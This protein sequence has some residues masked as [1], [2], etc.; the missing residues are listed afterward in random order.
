ML[1]S[2]V[3]FESMRIAIL[4]KSVMR[5][6]DWMISTDWKKLVKQH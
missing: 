2:E 3:E 4:K 5:S 6:T 1:P